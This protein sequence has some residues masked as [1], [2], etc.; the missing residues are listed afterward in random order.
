VKKAPFLLSTLTVVA[1]I[2]GLVNTA[3]V[4]I[5]SVIAAESSF[6][7]K[8]SDVYDFDLYTVSNYFRLEKL[9]F[10]NNH[11]VYAVGGTANSQGIRAQRAIIAMRD[12]ENGITEEEADALLPSLGVGNK[13]WYKAIVDDI[14]PSATNYTYPKNISLSDNLPDV[15]YIAVQYGHE[16][17]NN[18]GKKILEDEFWVRTKVDYRKCIHSSVFDISNMTCAVKYDYTAHTADLVALRGENDVLL[19][20][21]EAVIT[22]KEELKQALKARAAALNAQLAHMKTQLSS[23]GTTLYWADV[24]IG[25]MQKSTTELENSKDLDKPLADLRKL[26]QDVKDIYDWMIGEKQQENMDALQAELNAVRAELEQM[27]QDASGAANDIEKLRQ[28]L[29]E[30]VQKWQDT[31]K[32]LEISEAENQAKQMELD[33]VLAELNNLQVKLRDLQG[34]LDIT[35]Q[36]LNDA[37]VD[38]DTLRND[39]VEVQEQMKEIKREREV[40]MQR[41]QVLVGDQGKWQEEKTKLEQEQ[42][43]LKGENQALN[44]ENTA[45]KREK[46]ALLVRIRELE[47]A[48]AEKTACTVVGEVRVGEKPLNDSSADKTGIDNTNVLDDADTGDVEIPNLGGIETKTN[49]WW[50]TVVVLG[51]LGGLG[52]CCKKRFRRER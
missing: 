33:V 30:A 31:Q 19:P 45:L 2:S 15:L 8:I 23:V 38:A 5:P 37:K 6:I 17:V 32:L 13:T 47:K 50:V 41:I 25:N 22:W 51:I 10:R 34:E 20:E 11:I 28:D 21:N 9:D 4:P 43:I 26:L 12:Y 16:T 36:E 35:K 42:N 24:A 48:L 39:L 18:D 7:N 27:L 40:L 3:F 1:G 52:F 14:K 29:V 44:E 46:E 49:F